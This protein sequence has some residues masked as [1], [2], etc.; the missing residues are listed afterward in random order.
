MGQYLACGVATCISI[1]KRGYETEE[2]LED[3]KLK[4]N[5]DIFNIV[6][7][8]K[9]MCLEIKED[10]FEEN[11]ID[12][13]KSQ[14]T[15]LRRRD[16]DEDLE[17][18][19]EFKGKKFD[20]MI[21]YSKEFNRIPFYY[22]EGYFKICNIASYIFTNVNCDATVDLVVYLENG[23]IVMEEWFSMFCYLRDR[24]VK[25]TDNPLKDAVFVVI[26]G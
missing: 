24:I 3:L 7:D 26:E 5:L 16:L 23:K 11:I 25:S 15:P 6:D 1:N 4:M 2:I 18:L 17:F 9:V 8:E 12:F 10:I 20:E 21:N 14:I 13:I 22:S 19:D